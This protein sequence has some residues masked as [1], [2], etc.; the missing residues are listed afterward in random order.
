MSNQYE[1]GDTVLVRLPNYS[2]HRRAIV[3]GYNRQ[4]R[5][6]NVTLNRTGVAHEVQLSQ[7]KKLNIKNSKKKEEMNQFINETSVLTSVSTSLSPSARRRQ[8]KDES[9][10]KIQDNMVQ[11]VESEIIPPPYPECMTQKIILSY[12]AYIILKIILYV[13]FGYA[14][15]LLLTKSLEA[16]KKLILAD[17]FSKI[18]SF[19]IAFAAYPFKVFPAVS[20][21]LGHLLIFVS[22]TKSSLNNRYFDSFLPIVLGLG[23]YAIRTLNI[24]DFEHLFGNMI[25]LICFYLVL[26]FLLL[27]WNIFD[28]DFARNDYKTMI[29]FEQHSILLIIIIL[30]RH[31]F[32]PSYS[33][34]ENYS[35]YYLF[36]LGY[37]ASICL[38]IQFPGYPRR[39]NFLSLLFA[40]P[41]LLTL[42]VLASISQ[43]PNRWH[44]LCYM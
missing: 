36:I 26:S 19:T 25:V 20:L 43:V 7:I 37:L 3:N 2:I 28:R 16:P 42:P 18:I 11:S 31:K 8:L 17:L 44:I 40:R 13:F 30:I 33:Y 24:Y 21:F 35:F 32:L 9:Q 39:V 22:L 38:R 1:S 10:I 29:F 27:V 41:F 5:V 34:V 15:I 4:L 6:Y 14:S 23:I 12:R